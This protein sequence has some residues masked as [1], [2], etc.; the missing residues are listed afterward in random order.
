MTEPY[1]EIVG[2]PTRSDP[3]QVAGTIT[4]A[5]PVCAAPSGTKCAWPAGEHR[6]MPHLSRLLNRTTDR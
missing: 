6:R 3:Y 5:C 1:H 4:R 2:I